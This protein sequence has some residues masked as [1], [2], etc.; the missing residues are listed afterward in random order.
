MLQC[1]IVFIVIIQNLG[2][3]PPRPSVVVSLAVVLTCNF[4]QF[5]IHITIHPFWKKKMRENLK[6]WGK[7]L[8]IEIYFKNYNLHL[9]AALNNDENDDDNWEGYQ[10]YHPPWQSVTNWN[11][12]ILMTIN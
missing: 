10:K 6:N 11:E 5:C 7:M 2:K 3:Q 8:L 9:N 12:K 4:F 1:V